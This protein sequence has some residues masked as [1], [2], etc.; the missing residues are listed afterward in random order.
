MWQP[1]THCPPHHFMF[2]PPDGRLEQAGAW[3]VAFRRSLRSSEY[4]SVTPECLLSAGLDSNT[5]LIQ[6]FSS[7]PCLWQAV[8]PE[9][10]KCLWKQAPS[11][12]QWGMIQAL[13]AGPSESLVWVCN[14][15]SLP[16][17]KPQLL[18]CHFLQKESRNELVCRTPCVQPELIIYYKGFIAPLAGVLKVIQIVILIALTG[19]PLEAWVHLPV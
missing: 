6:S 16:L 4:G 5:R 12:P 19:F 14:T 18:F 11:L 13:P 15:S 3:T 1:P 2:S 8:Q 7:E 10:D 9:H 17:R